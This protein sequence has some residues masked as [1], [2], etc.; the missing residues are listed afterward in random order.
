[1]KTVHS[2]MISAVLV[3]D[4]SDVRFRGALGALDPIGNGMDHSEA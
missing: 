1:M 2:A 3:A 4:V